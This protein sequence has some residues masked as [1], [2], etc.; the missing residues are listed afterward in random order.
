MLTFA[1][2]SICL[3]LSAKRK[4]DIDSLRFASVG[5]TAASM[6]VTCFEMEWNF[7]E[8]KKEK[9]KRKERERE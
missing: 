1:L 8:R 4:V 5:E 7:N 6:I 3:A 2:F 9:G